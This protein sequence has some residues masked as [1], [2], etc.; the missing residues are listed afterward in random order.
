MRQHGGGVATLSY[1]GIGRHRV[2]PGQ[3]A[4]FTWYGISSKDEHGNE[5]PEVVPFGWLLDWKK[6]FTTRAIH[7]VF[8]FLGPSYKFY[9]YD[10]ITDQKR[11][12]LS[13]EEPTLVFPAVTRI[14]Q[15]AFQAVPTVPQQRG[16]HRMSEQQI[17]WP[18]EAYT[19]HLEC[20]Q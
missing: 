17:K 12:E 7:V 20:Q 4:G 3:T 16:R 11:R 8:P 9:K 19:A 6:S 5:K 1:Q 14:P 10:G 15:Q 13:A 18:T 2:K